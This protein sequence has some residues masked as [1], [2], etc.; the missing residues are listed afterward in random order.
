MTQVAVAVTKRQNHIILPKG[1]KWR[2]AHSNCP[3]AW[4]SVTF[5]A[6][7]QGRS[8]STETRQQMPGTLDIPIVP[9]SLTAD[10]CA[11]KIH[12]RRSRALSHETLFQP[13]M[14]SLLGIWDLRKHLMSNANLRDFLSNLLNLRPKSRQNPV[15]LGNLPNSFHI[16]LS[17]TVMPLFD[18][19]FM[20][21]CERG[22]VTLLTKTVDTIM[23]EN[24]VQCLV[25]RILDQSTPVQLDYFDIL[26]SL[27]ARFSIVG[28]CA[29]CGSI[30]TI[31]PTISAFLNRVAD[32]I[33]DPEYSGR[34]WKTIKALFT[35][36]DN[37]LFT[38]SSQLLFSFNSASRC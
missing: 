11:F 18:R 1:R 24:R 30:V 2:N 33:R 7:E 29:G 4:L 36:S 25:D 3:K 5:L 17:W 32:D 22:Y 13:S 31:V 34:I 16:Q 21:Y 37:N 6:S 27:Y 10:R 35:I 19:D 20:R 8:Y 9:R 23:Q 12:S 28:Y 15:S 14:I 38:L 26:F